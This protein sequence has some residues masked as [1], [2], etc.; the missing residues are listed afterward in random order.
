M[1]EMVTSKRAAFRW[2]NRIRMFWKQS[3][4]A[5]LFAACVSLAFAQKSAERPTVAAPD[6]SKEAYTIDR[7]ASRIVAESNGTG[8]REVTA[9]VKILADAGVKTFAVLSFTYTGANE[10]VE[11][12]YVRVRKPDG[13]VVKTPDYNIQDMPAEVTRT[14][15]L[16]SDIHEKHVAVKSLGVGD[17]L[18]Y[19][20]RYRI[21]KPEVPG[22]FWYE[23]S[24][25]KRAVAK[26]EQLEISVPRE[27]HLRVVSPEFKP[28]VNEEGAR[29]VYRWKQSNLTVKETD[30][31]EGARRIPPNPDVQVT[32]FA[33]WEE[34]G[35]WYRGL[36]KDSLQVTPAI[37]AK[38][39][40]LTKGLTSDEDKIRAIYNFVSLKY[41][42]IGLDFGIGR[43]QP[44]TAD[45]V[46]DNGYGDCKDKHTL[47]A[48]L[49]QA[50]GIEAWP[51]LVHTLRKLDSDVPS[52]AQF[53]HVISLVPQ[54]DRF[55]W[56]DTTPEVSPYG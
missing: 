13:S 17:V 32:T 21:V 25:V 22:Q 30:P 33:S 20:V 23:Y 27:K 6:F 45:D 2:S 14:A 34:V 7:L 3:L 29:R 54:G 8:S 18:E 36:Q 26:D 46:L 50:V 19:L 53:N 31:N 43:Y 16:Y 55:I 15:P 51:V 5:L 4:A 9:E 35:K 42:Y 11:I 40:A 37:Q 56:L 10:T 12:D 52:P 47:L 39:A 38:A 1:P 41:H 24:F 44:H 28:E 49:L 48:S